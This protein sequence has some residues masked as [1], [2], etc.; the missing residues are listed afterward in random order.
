MMEY[1]FR[2]T[3]GEII[4]L[5]VCQYCQNSARCKEIHEI[6]VISYNYLFLYG[7]ISVWE[8]KMCYFPTQY[9]FSSGSC[10]QIQVVLWFNQRNLFCS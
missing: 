3:I 6:N 7:T 2:L 9:F 4:L 8:N 10:C 1:S 5:K